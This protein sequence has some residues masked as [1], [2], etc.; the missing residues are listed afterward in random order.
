MLVKVY[1][2]DFDARPIYYNNIV[3]VTAGDHHIRLIDGN[4]NEI[5][6][7]HSEVDYHFIT[8]SME[9]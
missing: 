1:L 4:D 3:D 9:E 2:N 8:V 7:R 5:L 6:I